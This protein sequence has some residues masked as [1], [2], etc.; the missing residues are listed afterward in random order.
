MVS[1]VT[2]WAWGIAPTSGSA[3]DCITSWVCG[4]V[5]W[6]SDEWASIR[7]YF[8]ALRYQ[9]IIWLQRINQLCFLKQSEFLSV[10]CL[11][12]YFWAGL[13]ELRASRQDIGAGRQDIRL[14]DK[15]LAGLLENLSSCLWRRRIDVTLLKCLYS[16]SFLRF[17]F[18]EGRRAED[19]RRSVC[20]FCVFSYFVAGQLRILIF[21]LLHGL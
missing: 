7:S 6:T 1:P 19:L 5:V 21:T 20:H 2:H 8:V 16:P 14:A 15:T 4:Q 3:L 9:F 10:A 17:L 12:G 18:V 13:P 11:C